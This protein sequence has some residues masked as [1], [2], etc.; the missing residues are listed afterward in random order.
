M[1]A[2]YS[3]EQVFFDAWRTGV[4]LAGGRYFGDGTHSPATAAN[5]WDL[6]PDIEYISDAIG[7]L[8]S[9]ERVFIAAMVSFYSADLG[10]QLLSDIGVHGLSDISAALD[11]PR[12]EVL[13]TLL[14][15]YPGW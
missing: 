13:S 9:G 12:L 1:T 2:S 8:S 10:G 14:L 6:A 5:K 15:S 7:L 4:E 11:K 3:N